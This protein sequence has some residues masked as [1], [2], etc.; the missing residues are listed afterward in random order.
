MTSKGHDSSLSFHE[1]IKMMP[2]KR[3]RRVLYATDFSEASRRAFAA[4]VSIAKSLDARLTIL[5]VLPPVLLTL[6]EQYLDAVTLDQLDKQARRWSAQELDKLNG[7]AKRAG[8]RVTS[9]LR[10]GDASDQI[11]RACRSTKADLMVVGTHGRRG[12][13]KFFL[14]SVAERVVAMAPCPVVT[15]RGK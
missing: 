8:V 4:A 11:V 5:Y 7:R 13:P 14:G 15:V 1:R 3:I 10:D 6:P 12:L 2:M 9:L